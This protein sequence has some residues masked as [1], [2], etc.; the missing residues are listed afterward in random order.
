[1][2]WISTK[3]SGVFLLLVSLVEVLVQVCIFMQAFIVLFF[4]CFEMQWPLIHVHSQYELF[5]L[6]S[7]RW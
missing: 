6:I 4:V 7:D 1:M 3:V 5:V 2:L